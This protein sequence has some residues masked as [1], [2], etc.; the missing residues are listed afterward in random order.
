MARQED[1]MRPIT[2]LVACI[3]AAPL[4]ALG[5]GPAPGAEALPTT[6][7]IKHVILVIGE[8][9]TFDNIFGT[10]LPPQGQQ[11]WNLL[12]RGIVKADG[13]PGPH[14]PLAAQWRAEEDGG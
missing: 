3:L 12:S 1:P 4:A 7:Q 6:T 5:A 2:A 13:S 8:N 14:F 10:W 9:R 11:V